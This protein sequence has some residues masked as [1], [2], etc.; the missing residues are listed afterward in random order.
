MV[1]YSMPDSVNV[2]FCLRRRREECDV[3]RRDE[4]ASVRGGFP[5]VSPRQHVHLRHLVLPSLQAHVSAGERP[6][7]RLARLQSL[8]RQRL[9]Q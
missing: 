4:A 8:P 7:R 5:R 1:I 9:L 3:Q 6:L 2:H